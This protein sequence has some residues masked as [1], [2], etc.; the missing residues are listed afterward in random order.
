MKQILLITD[1][2]SNVGINPVIAASHAQEEG[3]TVNVVGIVDD[4]AQAQFG[5][6]EINEIA[7]AGGGISRM[8]TMRDLS[9]TVQMMTRKTVMQTIQHAVHRELKQ[10][11]GAESLEELSPAKRGEVVRVMDNLSEEAPLQIALLIDTSASMK[12][13]LPAVED[14]IR[15]LMLSLQARQGKSELCIFHFPGAN[16]EGS[17]RVTGWTSDMSKLSSLF[18]RLNMRGTTP[19]GPALMEVI[20]FFRTGDYGRKNRQETEGMH[21]GYVV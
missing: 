5:V 2:C 17:V 20:D 6:A 16:H 7:E 19:T 3:I 4:D 15:D 10:V 12:P 1:G 8:V 21:G 9:K 11:L 13:K 18:T 14:A